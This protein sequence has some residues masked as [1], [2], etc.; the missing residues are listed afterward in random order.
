VWS[1]QTSGAIRLIVLVLAGSVAGFGCAGPAGEPAATDEGA[2]V[3]IDTEVF[4]VVD[5]PAFRRLLP[6]DAELTK[7][8]GDMQFVEGP[9]WIDRDGGYLV[10][11]DIPANELKRWDPAGGLQTFRAPSGNANGN[12]VDLQG[13]LLSAQHDGRVTRTNA[14]GTVET[15]VE[16]Y[17]GKRLSSP[18]DLVVTSDGALWFTD[19]PYGLGNRPQ[20]TDGNYVYRLAPDGVTLAPVVTDMDRPNGLC[21][22]PDERILYVANSGME[23]RHIRT[24]AVAPDGTVSGGEVF[25][26]LDQGF[27]DGIRCDELG[28]VWSSSGDGAQIFSPSGQ[29]IARILLPEGAANLAFGGPDGRTVYFTARTSLYSIPALV[30]DAHR[31]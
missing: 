24:F 15:V 8:A 31:R 25:A 9:V 13:R 28:N 20:E 14:D 10:F 7:L 12:T 21:F 27:P 18:N 1:D 26:T 29:L 2:L 30:R 23:L 22:S 16:A 3:P 11:S 6:A 4:A 19:P 17:A 5:E